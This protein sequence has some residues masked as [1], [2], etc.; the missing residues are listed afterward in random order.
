MSHHERQQR[1]RK[2]NTN[3][4]FGK[5]RNSFGQFFASGTKRTAAPT[6]KLAI[7][8]LEARHLL[9]A[10]FF[11]PA[12]PAGSVNVQLVPLA[13][14]AA[15]TQEIVTFG[16]PFTRGSVNQAQLGQVRVLKNGVEIPA[17][18]GQVRVRKDS[19]LMPACDRQLTPLRS[20]DCPAFDGKSVRV[21]QIDSP[22]TVTT[23]NP[24]SSTVQWGGP[25]RTLNRT[26]LQ[27][28]RIEWHTVTSGTFVAA[29][30]VE[31]PDVLPVL[32]KEYLAKGMLDARTDPTANGVSETRDDPA[33]MDAMNFSGYTEYDYAE[34]NLFYTIIN[35]K[36]GIT[37]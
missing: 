6:A 7:E 2:Q 26:T 23:L 18:V 33:T 11:A 1:A 14:V 19:A 17:F 8:Q 15:G 34:K 28:P 16:V 4:R 9:A 20:I 21:P 30:N 25:A 32:P 31:E 24:E 10:Q 13:N 12:E 22:Y 27:D 37:G 35:Q 29:D 3:E 5:F 36:P